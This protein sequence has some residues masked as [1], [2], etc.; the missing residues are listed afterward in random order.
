MRLTSA[1][2]EALATA[3]AFGCFGPEGSALDRRAALWAAGVV[4]SVRAEHLPG[5]AVG[6]DA[7]ALPGLSPRS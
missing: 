5:I 7:P 2:A 4:A 1:Q 3:G 6:L